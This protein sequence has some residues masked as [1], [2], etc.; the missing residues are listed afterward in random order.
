MLGKNLA[1]LENPKRRAIQRLWGIPDI[2]TRQKWKAVWPFLKALPRTQLRLLDAGCGPGQWALEL[3]MR[4]PDWTITGVDADASCIARASQARQKLQLGNVEFHEVDFFDYSASKPYDAIL[5]ICSAH[6]CAE[7]GKGVQLFRQFQKWLNPG[8][9]LLLLVPRRFSEAPFSPWLPH[10]HW[11]QV[12]ARGELVDL[13][14]KNRLI[15]EHLS[16]EIGKL[17]TFAKQIDFCLLKRFKGRSP[18]LP[19]ILYSFVWSIS[20]LDRNFRMF[21][22]TS[23]LFWLL[24]AHKERAGGELRE[25]LARA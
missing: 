10:Q 1:L 23:S 8:G 15:I 5:S 9:Q 24:I 6:I 12:F 18:L 17:G 11:Q 22:E 13:C 14:G 7:A 20:S 25:D 16:G 2:H 21:K 19:L 3:A 4:R